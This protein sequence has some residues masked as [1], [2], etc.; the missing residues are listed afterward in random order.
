MDRSG[1]AT[2]YNFSVIFHGELVDLITF[3]LCSD[4]FCWA[5]GSPW[6][7]LFA[8][9]MGGS[10]SAQTADLYCFWAFHFL[11]A[12]SRQWGKLSTSPEGYPVWTSSTGHIMALAQFRDNIL[13]AP[14]GPRATSVV[15]DVCH[16]LT[17]VWNLPVLCPCMQNPGDLCTEACMTP[18]L[19]ALGVCMHRANGLGTCIAHFTDE[20]NLKLEPPLQFAWAVQDFAL[21]NLYT[22]VLVNALPFIHSWGAQLL[23]CAAWIP[24]LCS[25]NCLPSTLRQFCVPV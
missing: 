2:D 20:W 16:T 19:L 24:C 18:D 7:R 1:E 8:I 13:V 21:A 22:S 4:N 5:A 9:P 3:S 10:F 15:R 11:K 14:A 23:S 6:Q 25:N 12:R 17:S